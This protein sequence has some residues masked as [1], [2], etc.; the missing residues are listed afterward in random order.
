[1]P[2][3]HPILATRR[4]ICDSSPG[5]SNPGV[6]EVT[7][8]LW[9]YAAIFKADDQ[10]APG[11]V[12]MTFGGDHHTIDAALDAVFSYAYMRPEETVRTEAN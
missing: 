4:A 6:I 2:S 8:G 12:M 9:G 5:V 10:R 11:T 1:M 3:A 7:H